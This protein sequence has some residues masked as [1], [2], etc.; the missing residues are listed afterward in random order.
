MLK[1][2]GAR[3]K[4][5]VLNLSYLRVSYIKVSRQKKVLSELCS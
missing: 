4:E 5:S 1:A 2:I 3:N